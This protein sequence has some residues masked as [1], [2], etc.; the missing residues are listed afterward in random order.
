MVLYFPTEN[1]VVDHKAK[2][3]LLLVSGLVESY[4]L[5]GGEL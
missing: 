2:A 1:R 4:D 3:G 5:P